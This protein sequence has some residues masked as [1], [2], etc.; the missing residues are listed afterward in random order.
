M[1]MTKPILIANRPGSGRTNLE[2]L[3]LPR[4]ARQA[5]GHRPPCF[6]LLVIIRQTYDLAPA[7]LAWSRGAS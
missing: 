1:N 5:P 7:S 2:R 6:R 3:A 4:N